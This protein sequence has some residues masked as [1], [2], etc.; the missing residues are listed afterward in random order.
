MKV[1]Q[2]LLVLGLAGIT[3]IVVIAIYDLWRFGQL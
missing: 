3:A 1:W 2:I